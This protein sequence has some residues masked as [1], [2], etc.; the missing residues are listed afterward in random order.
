VVASEKYSRQILFGPIGAEGQ[1]R[2]R[3]ATV[4]IIGCGALGSSQANLIARAGI[5][6][7]RIV[8]RD[9]VEESNLQRQGLFDESDAAQRLPKAAAAEQKLRAINSD[10][11]VE[12][13]VADATNRNIEELISG[14]DLLLDGSDNFET[15]YLMN[16]AAVKHNLPWIYG[17][18]VGSY[19]VSFTVLPGYTACLSC[20]FSAPPQGV[21]ETCDTAGVI[22][23]AVA[24][25]TAVQVTEALK[26]LLGRRADLHG[27]L[28]AY[29][30]WNNRRQQL[31]VH[32]RVDCDTCGGRHFTHLEAS[33]PWHVSMCGRNSVQIQYREPR[34]INL[35]TLRQRL[36]SFGP[37]HGNSYLL[38]CRVGDY[39][40]TVFPDGRA[41]IKGT[42]D[43]ALARSLYAR[44]VGS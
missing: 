27:M 8:D 14:V 18:V 28:L 10:V 6:T 3:R 37:V 21:Q 2:L 40:L 16:D 5:G 38:Q 31:R 23:P 1:E 41:I 34:S 42:Q 22:G 44:Y 19:G 20:V 26:V 39:E 43:P 12:G 30:I 32:R 11:R 13:V 17:A 24:W 4:V 35:G 29:D 9:F 15:R 33:A 25:V 7:L 36:S